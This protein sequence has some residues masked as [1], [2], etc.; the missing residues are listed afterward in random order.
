[1]YGPIRRDVLHKG[2]WKYKPHDFQMPVDKHKIR[3]KA[4]QTERDNRIGEF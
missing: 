4:K 3:E 2:L 1:M